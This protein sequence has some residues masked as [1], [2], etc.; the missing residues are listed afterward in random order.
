MDG[1]LPTTACCD[2]EV[3]GE[4]LADPL[5]LLAVDASGQLYEL[6]L[7]TGITAPVT[8]TAQWRVDTVRAHR[9][10]P[11]APLPSPPLIVG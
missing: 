3:V 11:P 7:A 6:N 9:L 5:R 1:S 2:Y 8:L 4:H 10:R